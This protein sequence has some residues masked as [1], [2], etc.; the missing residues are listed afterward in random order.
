M[1]WF[2]FHVEIKYA[3]R[4]EITKLELDFEL[5][6]G[7]AFDE[8]RDAIYKKI[9]YHSVLEWISLKTISVRISSV[10]LWNLFDS[11]FEPLTEKH[12]GIGEYRT[13]YPLGIWVPLKTLDPQKH[14]KPSK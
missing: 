4:N 6:D 11:A 10:W 7:Y 2:A 3:P 14:R 5:P 13:I 1:S 8:L 9:K 12:F